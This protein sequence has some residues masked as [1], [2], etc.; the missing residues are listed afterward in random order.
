[1]KNSKVAL[2]TAP[3][4]CPFIVMSDIFMLKDTAKT[5][6]NNARLNVLDNAS[7]AIYQVPLVG[8]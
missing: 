1:M 3:L 5:H 2:I 6:C 4:L 8:H 7:L